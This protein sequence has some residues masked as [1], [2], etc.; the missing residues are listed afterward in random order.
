MKYYA[1]IGNSNTLYDI[2]PNVKVV[3][4]LSEEL[5]MV[6]FTLKPIDYELDLDFKN[7]NGL[8][9]ITLF[10]DD[11]VYKYLYLSFYKCVNVA[12]SPKKMY[13][14]VLQC[15]SPTFNLQ[16]ITLPNKLITQPI[17]DTKRTIYEENIYD[18]RDGGNEY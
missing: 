4:K 13:K 18:S 6:E 7:Y 3:D 11:V 2:Y 12:Y 5:D 16:R 15:V 1:K 9:M 17:S 10:A 14:Y 8:I